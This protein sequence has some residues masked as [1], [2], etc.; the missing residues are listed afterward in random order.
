VNEDFLSPLLAAL[1]FPDLIQRFLPFPIGAFDRAR[2]LELAFENALDTVLADVKKSGALTHGSNFLRS[3][4]VDHWNP[5]GGTPA[6]VFNTTEV[7]SSRR[8]VIAPF[9]FDGSDLLFLPIAGQNTPLGNLSVSTAAILSARFPWITPA[10]TFRELERNET[11]RLVD[12]GYFENSG[13]ATAIDLIRALQVAAEQYGL[14]NKISLNLIVLTRGDFPRQEFYGLN[15]ILSPIQALLSTRQSRAFITIAEATRELDRDLPVGSRT[16]AM[17]HL[18]KINLEDMGYPHLWDGDSP[19][20]RCCL[21]RRKTGSVLNAN[22][23]TVVLSL[24]EITL[25]LDAFSMS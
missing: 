19:Q 4:F 12:G 6:L 23:K 11:V 9:K 13:V 24:V 7:G 1:V 22:C 3:R 17:M 5:E 8:R 18:R 14:A 25:R 20:S 2:R 16:L 21:F 15:E 10:G